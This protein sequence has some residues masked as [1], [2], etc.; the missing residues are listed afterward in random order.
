MKCED[1]RK[2]FSLLLYGELNF[3]QEEFC[4][5]HLD[6]CSACRE[7]LA[8]EKALQRAL[9][10]VEWTPPPEMLARSRQQL[11]R[12]LAN[13]EPA[14][15]HWW[16][17]LPAHL[18][19][20]LVIRFHPVPAVWQSAAAMALLAIGFFGA[21]LSPRENDLRLTPAGLVEP[22]VSRVRY[23]EPMAGDRVQIVLDETR[24]RVFSGNLED[25]DIQKLLLTAAKDPS[26][27]GLRVESVNLLKGRSDSVE[28]RSALLYAVQHDSNSG[29]RLKALD[30]LRAFSGDPETRR[31]LT[32]VLL[33]DQ[34]PGVR[35]QVIDLLV[36]QKNENMV[37][38]LQELMHTENNGYVRMRCERALH[39]MNASLE[40]F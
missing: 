38:V 6:E 9:T 21:R 14:K 23:V 39:E 29:V 10:S 3:D 12:A 7:E 32:Q 16:D 22:S 26:D 27:P 40:T 24:Q 1:V 36:Q 35:T 28:I 17:H 20:F 34:N 8:R 33:T 18:S 4:E 15:K 37:G 31:V 13:A 25:R 2:W 11:R 30:G 19:Q 5:A